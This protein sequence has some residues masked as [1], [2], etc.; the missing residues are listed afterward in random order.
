MRQIATDQVGRGTGA[1]RVGAGRARRR[2][3]MVMALAGAC[4]LFVP[5]RVGAGDAGAAAPGGPVCDSWLDWVYER[6]GMGCPNDRIL[7]VRGRSDRP[8][9]SVLVELDPRTGVE[10]TLWECGACNSPVRYRGGI[11]VATPSGI[12]WV[13][14]AGSHPLVSVLRLVRILGAPKD[15]P[16]KLLVVVAPEA[17]AGW[18]VAL[19][20]P[21]QREVRV[22]SHVPP[23]EGL[24][25]L[26]PD[27][28]REDGVV[29]EAH[30][31]AG[32]APLFRQGKGGKQTVSSALDRRQDL[33]FRRDPIWSPGGKVV[34]VKQGV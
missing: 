13:D 21:A 26:I 3:R 9:G 5:A 28:L 12:T 27:Q 33:F 32:R 17:G 11:A 34:Y 16:D 2:A 6:L 24:P 4:A 31:E 25:P 29:I 19:A 7:V 20:D 18:S 1:P 23:D 30:T 22:I 15:S 10:R 8:M 14:S